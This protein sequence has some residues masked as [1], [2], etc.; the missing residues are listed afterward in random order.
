L[1]AIMRRFPLAAAFTLTLIATPVSAAEPVVAVWYRGTPTGTPRI[2]DLAAIK[3]AGFEAVTWPSGD[4]RS[5]ADVSRLAQRVGLLVVIHPQ[6]AAASL[7]SRLTIDVTHLG[8]SEIPAV[9]WRAVADGVRT[10][11]FDPGAGEGAGLDRRDGQ[12]HPWVGAAVALARQLSANAELVDGLRRAGAP[13]FLSL[14]P[15]ALDVQLLEGVRAWV[16][17]ATNAGRTA[18]GAALELP[19][20]VPYAIWVSLLDASTIAMVD[21]PEGARW[22]FELAAGA[23]A[24]YVIDKRVK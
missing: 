19:K 4:A 1:T 2:D 13:R 21:R 8:A 15:T 20:G 24:V 11:S 22:K 14:R 18:V 17:I 9:A 3:A 7:E 12:R 5:V 16:I 23:A 10:I 6:G